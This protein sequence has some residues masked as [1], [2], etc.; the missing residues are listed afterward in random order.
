MTRWL[1]TGGAGQLGTHLTRLLHGDDVVSTT[2]HDLDVTD[3]AAVTALTA[4]A[5]Q[6]RGCHNVTISMKC[7]R[8]QLT[9]NN[10]NATTPTLTGTSLRARRMRRQGETELV[11]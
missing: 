1:I 5:A 6:Y 7:V 11:T 8:P 10:P 4:A 9:M 3:A 2:R